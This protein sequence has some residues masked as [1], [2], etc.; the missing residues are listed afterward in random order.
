MSHKIFAVDL[1][2]LAVLESELVVLGDHWHQRIY[3]YILASISVMMALLLVLNVGL[4]R[5]LAL[6]LSLMTPLVRFGPQQAKGRLGA[7][8]L[9]WSVSNNREEER[10]R[11]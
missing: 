7:G 9:Q 5:I 10:G 8:R 1:V 2:L 4:G 11:P 6:L 3:I